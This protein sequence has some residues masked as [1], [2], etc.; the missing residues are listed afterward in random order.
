MKTFRDIKLLYKRSLTQTLRNPITIFVSLFQPLLYLFLF[1]PLLKNIGG[2]PGLPT[3][4]TTEIFIPGLLV[5]MALFSSAF[6]GFEIINEIRSGLIERFLVT[7]VSRAA[8]LWGRILRDAT[9]LLVQCV[10]IT[11]AAIPF[12]LMINISGF[13]ISLVLYALMAIAMTS[14]S[15]GFALIYKTERNLATTLNM[16]T[17][18]VS[19]LS[20]TILPLILAPLWLQT[21]S[22]I[23]PFSYAVN[24]SRS[25]FI[26]NFQSLD[27]LYS[28]V[29]IALL[30]LLIFMWALKAL[31]KIA[32]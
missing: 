26:G 10:L 29:I 24:A 8:I 9:V 4:R 7:R 12:G 25:L 2:V 28:F 3:G 19:L 22:K 1:M 6:V 27:I 17:L 30:A 11:I 13:L 31:K 20:G 14:M 15:Y 18:P 32:S 16:I 5:M 21:L 23:N